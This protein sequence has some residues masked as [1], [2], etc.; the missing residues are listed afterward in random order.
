MLVG[1]LDE[2]FFHRRPVLVGVEPASMVWSLGQKAADR[3]GPTWSQALQPWTALQM[4]LAD[5][6]TGRQR[7]IAQVQQQRRQGGQIPLENG[8]DVFHT[9]QEGQRAL[10]QQWHQVAALWEEAEAAT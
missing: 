7:G 2:I 1:C 5:A 10:S 3:T 8:L 9:T 4:V 6:G